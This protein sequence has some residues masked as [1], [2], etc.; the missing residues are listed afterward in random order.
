MMKTKKPVTGE[1]LKQLQ[2]VRDQRIPG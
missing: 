1:R 2:A